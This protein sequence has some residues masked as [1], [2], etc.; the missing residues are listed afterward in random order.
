MTALS[1][2]ALSKRQ[3]GE[4]ARPFG[5]ALNPLPS[6]KGGSCGKGS[7]YAFASLIARSNAHAAQGFPCHKSRSLPNWVSFQRFIGPA[8]AWLIEL[9]TPFGFRVGRCRWVASQ[10]LFPVIA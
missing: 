2:L 5:P 3:E 6:G 1:V 9:D 4:A 10:V 8:A 7:D